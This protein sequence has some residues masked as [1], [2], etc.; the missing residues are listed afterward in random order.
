MVSMHYLLTKWMDFDQTCTDTLFG[1]GEEY[2]KILVTLT[3]FQGHKGTLKCPKYCFH[4]LS[5]EPVF[6]FD[7]TR[8]DTL[9]GGGEG[10]IRFW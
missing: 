6:G 9:L 10:C 1:V 8:I 4:G 3:Y 7:Q 5:S 2:I